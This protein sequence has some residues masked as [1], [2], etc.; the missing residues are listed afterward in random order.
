MAPTP[1]TRHPRKRRRVDWELIACAFRGHIL[2]DPATVPE[3]IDRSIVGREIDGLPWYRCVRCDAWLAIEPPAA[4]VRPAPPEER[5]PLR[6]KALHDRIVLRLI[7]IDRVFHFLVLSLLGVAVLAFAADRAKLHDRF[8]QVTTALQSAIAGGPVSTTGHVGIVHDLDRLFTLSK[9]T[10]IEAGI[11]LLAYGALELVEA[12]GLWLGKR[13]AEYL[14]FVATVV[15]L[16]FE[17]YEL[18]EKV[19]PLKV[20]GFVINLAV[21]VYLIWAKRL[22]GVRGGGTV[23][24]RERAYDSGWQAIERTAPGA[25]PSSAPAPA[26]AGGA[27]R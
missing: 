14:T 26:A 17:V 7:A 16:P 8:Y 2:L 24:E 23:D 1:G 13:W 11:A 21:A 3:R 20:I 4:T 15:L 27:N 5:L 12:V 9:G 22:F 18:T 25:I 6:G 19:S 10:L